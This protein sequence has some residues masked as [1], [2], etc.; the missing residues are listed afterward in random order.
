[1]KTLR[2]DLPLQDKPLVTANLFGD[3][4]NQQD[5]LMVKKLLLELGLSINYLPPQQIKSAVL[6]RVDVN[7]NH[8]PTA[9]AMIQKKV[10]CRFDRPFITVSF[11]GPSETAGA[12]RDIGTVMGLPAR[13]TEAIIRKGLAA[14]NEGINCY[15]AELYGKKVLLLLEG[16]QREIVSRVLDDLGMSVIYTHGKRQYY[17][18]ESLQTVVEKYKIDLAAGEDDRFLQNRRPPFLL[19][20][21]SS[22]SWLGFKGFTNFARYISKILREKQ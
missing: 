3:F 4:Q 1:M 22:E 19:L 10:E 14:V 12:L 15:G 13:K 5:I 2:A 18:P 11:F 16:Y 7:I 17:T 21:N 6:Q 9:E 20:S 8:R